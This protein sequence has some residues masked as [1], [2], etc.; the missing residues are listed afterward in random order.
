MFDAT[1]R[2]EMV[3]DL[4]EPATLPDGNT[5]F[6]VP[7]E[8]NEDFTTAGPDGEAVRV[9]PTVLLTMEDVEKYTIVDG[10]AGTVI[11][12]LDSQ[13]R[14]IAMIK[15]TDGFYQAELGEV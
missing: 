1:D 15:T 5:I 3:E 13:S 11:E 12:L 14:I 6:V 9:H 7:D 10:E 4:G 8:H 2:A